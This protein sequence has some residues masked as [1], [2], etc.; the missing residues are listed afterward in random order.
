MKNS[1]EKTMLNKLN[2]IDRLNRLSDELDDKGD[3]EGS[4]KA[5]SRMWKLVSEVS[6]VI[7]HST[8]GQINSNVAKRMVFHMRPQLIALCKRFC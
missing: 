8:R 5:Y 4:M 3:E 1:V 7:V 6:E 2:E